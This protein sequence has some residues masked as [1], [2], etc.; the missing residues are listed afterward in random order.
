MILAAIRLSILSVSRQ[1]SSIIIIAAGLL[2]V[3]IKTNI[4]RDYSQLLPEKR[5][6]IFTKPQSPR[7]FRIYAAQRRGGRGGLAGGDQGRFG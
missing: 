4:R 2:V 7:R 5:P 1:V 3:I 6:P